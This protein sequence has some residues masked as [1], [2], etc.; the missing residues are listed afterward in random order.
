MGIRMIPLTGLF[1]KTLRIGRDVSRKLGKQVDIHLSGADTE[2]DKNVIEKLSDALMHIIRNSIDHGIEDQKSRKKKDKSPKGNVY[3]N[4]KYVGNEI[5]ITI[6]DDG[7][8]LDKE[9]IL[10]KAIEKNLPNANKD[11]LTDDEIWNFILLPGFST[12]TKVTGTSGRGVG[13]DVVTKNLEKIRGKIKIN[14]IKDKGSQIILKIPLTVSIIDAAIMKVGESS[15]AIPT[16]DIMEVFKI[17]ESQIVSVKN[18]RT[19]VK[20]RKNVYPVL[21]LTDIYEI[22]SN[23]QN[24]TDGIFILFEQGNKKVCLFADKI[25]DIQQVVIKPL[26][27]IMGI[28]KGISGQSIVGN[29]KIALMLDP[30]LLINEYLE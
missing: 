19:M 17:N 28:I 24:L 22:S 3:L 2:M 8:G 16:I 20:L 6:Q 14:S 4:A 10:K 18:K 1:N 13:M 26:S 11:N 30:Y 12:A 23:I 27:E 15:F 21:K 7:K 29:G 5:W 9:K 25:M